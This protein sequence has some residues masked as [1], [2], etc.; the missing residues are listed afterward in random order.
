MLQH[1]EAASA[2]AQL[3]PVTSTQKEILYLLL[4]NMEETAASI[5][6]LLGKSAGI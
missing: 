3:Q 5:S 2:K 1:T 6:V 4:R